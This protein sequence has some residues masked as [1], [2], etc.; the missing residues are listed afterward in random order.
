[1]NAMHFLPLVLGAAS[2]KLVLGAASLKR[3]MALELYSYNVDHEK[4]NWSLNN[5]HNPH[6]NYG[7][8]PGTGGSAR[9]V[10]WSVPNCQDGIEGEYPHTASLTMKCRE[11]ARL[12]DAY[13][14]TEFWKH[15]SVPYGFMQVCCLC[16][17]GIRW[18]CECPHGKPSA[19]LSTCPFQGDEN[20]DYCYDE[21]KYR[22]EETGWNGQQTCEPIPEKK[23]VCQNGQG[24]TATIGDECAFTGDTN[25]ARCNVGFHLVPTPAPT[26]K[27]ECRPN[28]CICD[29][30]RPETGTGCSF[31]GAHIC[32]SCDDGFFKFD[33]EC[34][35]CSQ[36]VGGCGWT[37]QWS[38]PNQPTTNETQGQAGNDGSLGYT[39]C[40]DKGYWM[41]TCSAFFEQ[42]NSCW[43]TEQWS[44]PGHEAGTQGFASDDGSL[45]FQCCCPASPAPTPSPTS[46]TPAPQPSIDPMQQPAVAN[47]CDTWPEDKTWG[48][49]V[50]EGSGEWVELADSGNLDDCRERGTQVSVVG[51]IFCVQFDS[52]GCRAKPGSVATKSGAEY[53]ITCLSNVPS[54][55]TD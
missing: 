35:T 42:N 47:I 12:E 18:G 38:C 37:A 16:G 33:K 45:A 53:A 49:A 17:G 19:D 21:T 14:V 32:A 30:G 40:C 4:A 13:T 8:V 41:E 15:T 22:L 43:W 20:C 25:C 2:L 26:P 6:C 24:T 44:C 46:P 31:D 5:G 11:V 48:C 9:G 36:N 28:Q 39:C 3:A 51:G 54:T 52:T 10:V 34:K 23:C 1:M 7:T 27:S 50:Q 29:N 55:P